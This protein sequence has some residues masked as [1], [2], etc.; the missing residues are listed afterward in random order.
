MCLPI[1]QLTPSPCLTLFLKRPPKS[2][3]NQTCNTLPPPTYLLMAPVRQ[4][5]RSV[6]E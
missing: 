4:T 5:I 1:V 3:E 6:L 2:T